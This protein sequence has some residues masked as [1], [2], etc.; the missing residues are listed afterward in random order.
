MKPAG[1]PLSSILIIVHLFQ[2]RDPLSLPSEG[3]GPDEEDGG[4]VRG[5]KKN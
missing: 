3:G 2:L 4:D 5:V 1:R